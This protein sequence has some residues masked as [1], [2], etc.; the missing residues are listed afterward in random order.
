MIA[1]DV[2]PSALAH[3]A[4]A[5][6]QAGLPPDIP[7]P[8]LTTYDG[9]RLPLADASVDRVA[10]FDALHHVPNKRTILGEIHRVLRRGGRACFAEP[11][12]GHAASLEARHEAAEWEVLEDEVDAPALCAMARDVGFASSYIVP[13]PVLSDNKFTPSHYQRVREGDRISA[14]DWTGNDALVVLS[15]L[16]DGVT[17]SRSPHTLA[18]EIELL[19]CPDVVEPDAVFV[20]QVRVTNVGDTIWLAQAPGNSGDTFDYAAAFLGSTER[21]SAQNTDESVAL[22]R[23]HIE[24]HSLEGTVT[25]GAQLWG[26]GGPALDIDYGRGF[27]REDVLPGAIASLAIRL[28]APREPGVYGLRFD[29]V[30]E[31]LSWFAPLGSRAQHAYVRVGRN[32]V[33]DSRTPNHLR[34]EIQVTSRPRRGVFVVSIRNTGDTIWLASP[35]LHG[36]WVQL[37]LQTI[38]AGGRVADRDWLRVPLP[39]DVVPVRLCRSPS[40]LGMFLTG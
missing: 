12:P 2:S 13:L 22:Y 4:E 28:R 5:I 27:F 24:R 8:T 10:C 3:G 15:K 11:G 1:V 32:T 29:C 40:T 17:D 14:L 25:V 33:P 18:A 35:L 7:T 23:S 30:A 6:R 21:R 19:D 39:V 31:S 37:G 20:V 9:F 34:A 26:M 16:L 36:G 38:D